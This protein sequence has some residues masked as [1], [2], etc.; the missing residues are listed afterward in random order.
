MFVL[1]LKT[2]SKL[3]NLLDYGKNRNYEL[4]SVRPRT[5]YKKSQPHVNI[6]I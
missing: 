6:I 3:E 1:L 2:P 4:W 5:R